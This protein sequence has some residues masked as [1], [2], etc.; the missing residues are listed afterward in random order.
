[1]DIVATRRALVAEVMERIRG[2]ASEGVN[3]DVLEKIRQELMGLA[4]RRELFPAEEFPSIAGQTSSM[5]RLSEDPDHRFALAVASPAEGRSTPPHLHRTWAVIAGIHGC[6]HN[7][8]Y[9]RLDDGTVEQNGSLDITPGQAYAMMPDDIHSI[10]LGENGP[11]CMLHLYGLSIEHIDDRMSFDMDKKSW[12]TFPA[13]FG[14]K[15]AAGAL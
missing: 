12:K 15:N 7:R 3:R 8:F 1:M 10:H 11:H 14:V 9:R 5:Y 4:K 6:E 13:A 2:L